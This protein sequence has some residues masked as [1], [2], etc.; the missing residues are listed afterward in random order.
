[1]RL[2]GPFPQHSD[3]ERAYVLHRTA[4]VSVTHTYLSTPYLHK[5]H[6]VLMNEQVQSY[7][8]TRTHTHAHT[9]AQTIHYHL[10]TKTGTNLIVNGEG[11]IEASDGHRVV[12]QREV[13]QLHFAVEDLSTQSKQ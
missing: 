8:H 10:H 7:T 12:S 13:L 4:C 2:S 11:L 1:M 3:T 6:T 9:R 5:Q